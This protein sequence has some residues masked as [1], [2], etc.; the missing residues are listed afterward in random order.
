MNDQH[1]SIAV[2]SSKRRKDSFFLIFAIVKKHLLYLLSGCLVFVAC[3]KNLER[4]SWDVDVVAPV[5]YS[6]LT[7]HDLIPDSLLQVN[8]DSSVTL[9]FDNTIYKMSLDTLVNLPDT[10][11]VDSFQ[12]PSFVPSQPVN[13]GQQI[14]AQTDESTFNVGDVELTDA[15]LKSGFCEVLVSSTVDQPVDL[16]Y[17][18]TSA[19]LGG[20]VFTQTVTVPA[21][22]QLSPATQSA[23]F[24]LSGA[25]LNLRGTN[26]PYNSYST[27]MVIKMSANSN[28]TNLNPGD[29]VKINATFGDLVPRFAKGYFGNRTISSAGQ[30]TTIDIFNKITDGTLDIDQVDV[31]FKVTN[32]IGAD[33]AVVISQLQGYNSGNGNSL[34]LNH[35]L[36]G[37][38]IHLNRATNLGSSSSPTYYNAAMNNSNSNID[39]LIELLPDQMNIGFDMELN[40]LGDISGH[41][42][43]IYDDQT[44]EASLNVTLP[45]HLIANNLTL[46]DTL[47]ISVTKGANGY[48]TQGTFNI[49]IDNGF[50]LSGNLQL[51]FFDIYGHLTDSIVSTGNITSAQTNASNIVTSSTSSTV[52]LQLNE[53]QMNRLYSGDRLILKVIFNTSSL[54]QHVVIY[55]QY[56]INFKIRGDFNYLI[57]THP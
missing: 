33:A 6:T 41:N 27:H 17:T 50:P 23:S 31:N 44:L 3:R 26:H 53:S 56:K 32:W 36:I 28:P 48:V 21:G 55:D 54:T 7:I 1:Q 13:P 20:T 14:F 51:Y 9:V 15:I 4:P 12:L 42:D 24:D 49:D 43:F 52:Q 37:S 8:P 47:N 29:K 10:M 5:V 45:L 46:A 22:S 34:N 16:V 30:N 39:Q 18:I 19:T 11:V 40:P 2:R 57:G 35:N 25:V 38:T